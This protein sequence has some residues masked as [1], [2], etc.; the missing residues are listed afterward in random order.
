MRHAH[1]ATAFS[2]GLESANVASARNL[3]AVQVKH[4]E[5]LARLDQSGPV[6]MGERPKL[7]IKTTKKSKV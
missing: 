6:C 1:D 3:S 5:T 2:F 4:C 7:G